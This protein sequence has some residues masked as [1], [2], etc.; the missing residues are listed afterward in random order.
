MDSR[1]NPLGL[2]TA[3]GEELKSLSDAYPVGRIQF[4]AKSVERDLKGGDKQY[5]SVVCDV[6][7]VAD[8]QSDESGYRCSF[9]SDGDFPKV[10]D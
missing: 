9:V 2:R 3:D 7:T 4:R 5:F 10:E 1:Y 6:K 8:G